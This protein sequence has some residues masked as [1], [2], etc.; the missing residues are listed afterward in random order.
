MGYFEITKFFCFVTRHCTCVYAQSD[1]LLADRPLIVHGFSV[2]GFVWGQIL[3]AM[4]DGRHEGLQDVL[5][6]SDLSMTTIDINDDLDES[7]S[8]PLEG[9]SGDN[10]GET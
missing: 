2:G 8:P 6:K 5:E 7:R 1:G 9:E 4:G 10:D 3:L